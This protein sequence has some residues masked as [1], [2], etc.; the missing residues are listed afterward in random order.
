MDIGADELPE[1]AAPPVD[2]DAPET[3]ILSGP[4]KKTRSKR[5]R[6]DFTSSEAGSTYECALDGKAFNRCIP[7]VL[8]RKLKPRRHVY[9]VRA[10]DAAGNVDADPP[11]YAWKVKKRPKKKG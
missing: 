5:A 7:P 6:I 3:T 10:I 1:A 11:V 2:L 9:E 8:L 4:P